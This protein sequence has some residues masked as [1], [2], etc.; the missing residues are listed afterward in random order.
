MK[1]IIALLLSVFI[2]LTLVPTGFAQ[3][4][5]EF[6]VSPDGS[7]SAPGT[8]A[9]PF[10]TVERARE[11]LKSAGGGTAY[12]REGDYVITKPIELDSADSGSV[13]T[14]YHGEKVRFKASE[15]IPFSAFGKISDEAAARLSDKSAASKVLQADLKSLGIT[16]YGSLKYYDL[17]YAN[18][19]GDGMPSLYVNGSAMTPAR[20]PNEGYL[21][22]D[23]VIESGIDESVGITT[24]EDKRHPFSFRCSD[25]RIDNWKNANDPWVRGFF[26][27]DYADGA[28][29]VTI[30]YDNKKTITTNSN[31]GYGVD[32]DR[33]FYFFNLLEEIDAPGEWY[34][35][36][37]TGM[38]YL[39]PSGDLKD[40][41]I[42]FS[43]FSGAMFK[44]S[45]TD[46]L[47]FRGITFAECTG[48]AIEA[49]DSK[50]IDINGC[51]FTNISNFAAWLERVDNSKIRNCH[52]YH[53]G[54]LVFYIDGGDSETLTPSGNIVTNNH[55]E[56]YGRERKTYQSAIDFRGVGAVISHNKIHNA[57]HF[58]LNYA[59]QEHIVEYNEIYDVCKDSSD[60][61]AVYTGQV[62]YNRG[63]II[64]YNYFHDMKAI[65]SNQGMKIQ[66]V[67]LDDRHCS[68]A[69]YG[70]IFYRVSAV[71]L[72]GG[73]RNNTFENNL[74]LECEYPFSM[75]ARGTWGGSWSWLSDASKWA[76]DKLEKLPYKSGVWLEKYPE[77]A[78]MRDD[79]PDLPKYNVI[80]NN[81]CYKTD[82]PDLDPLVRQYGTVEN[83]ITVSDASSFGGYKDGDFSVKNG[84]E[85]KEK[86]PE[87]KDIPTEK[88]GLRKDADEIL[89]KSVILFVGSPRAEAFGK[90][91][92][93]DPENMEVSPL[94]SDGRTLVPLRFIAESFGAEVS[95]DGDTK[96][97]SINAEGKNIALIIGSKKITVN[98]EESELDVP[99]QVIS[100]RT[101]IPLRAVAEALGKE[102]FWDGKGLIAMSGNELIDPEDTELIDLVINKVY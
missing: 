21:N 58:A 62:M 52:A 69:V 9:A 81:V 36:R 63:N 33:R 68:T 94:I 100:E 44:A 83:N 29:G 45:G 12:F 47:T 96:T 82:E 70:N 64:R 76:W 6:F 84:S 20:Y 40:A 93:V 16:E 59:G 17:Y 14:A 74:M 86:L 24:P 53:N 35:D 65:K 99:A 28:Y 10:K 66:A 26:R 102:V 56:D 57:P 97:V 3:E 27:Y 50:N 98:G 22:I 46:G 1:K 15:S 18:F 48:G 4:S 30:D 91:T 7:D 25:K 51:N 77:L 39:Y 67:Y 31:S 73:G 49:K 54:S 60:S 92:F 88:I 72:Y 42:A 87:W 38:L 32:T 80:K 37:E 95:W 2:I 41:D 75:D 8:I 5:A 89:Q 13:Y 78:A 71:A 85:I 55:I 61:G 43:C 79:E 101:V 34:L 19:W 23:T 11:A 90:T